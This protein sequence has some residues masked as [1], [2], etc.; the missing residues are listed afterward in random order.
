MSN[1]SVWNGHRKHIFSKTLSRVETFEN[2]GFPGFRLR[3]SQKKRRFSTTMMSYI[4]KQHHST[5][6]LYHSI[7]HAQYGMVSYF[8]RFSNFVWTGENNSNTSRVDAFTFLFRK[9]RKNLRFQINLAT[10]GR[11]LS[12]HLRA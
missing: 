4:K 6:S 9:R 12:W 11:G 7:T 1:I 10:C 5:T 2:A 3:L 8:H